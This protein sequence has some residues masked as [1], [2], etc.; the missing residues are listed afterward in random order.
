VKEL[1]EDCLKAAR[2][3]YSGAQRLAFLIAALFL[4]VHLTTVTQYLRREPAV[5]QAS[6]TA[7]T[8]KNLSEEARQIADS[9][10][11]L[12]KEQAGQIKDLTESFVDKLK[13]DLHQVD[14][15]IDRARRGLPA[16]SED[17]DFEQQQ[18]QQQ[19]RV[20]VP[21]VELPQDL[22]AKLRSQNTGA[23]RELVAPWIEEHFIQARLNGLKDEWTRQVWPKLA[24]IGA[25]LIS[26][27]DEASKLSPEDRDLREP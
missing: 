17:Q 11:K 26:R 4:A 25:D 22:S 8:A 6:K 24:A 16:S 23:I 1:L 27:I 18:Q 9:T 12:A 3:R 10:G 13:T 14:V 2:E 19:V 7:E 15:A 21:K 20:I 5:R